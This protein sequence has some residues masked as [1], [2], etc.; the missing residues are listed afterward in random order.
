MNNAYMT[1]E[2]VLN[3]DVVKDISPELREKAQHLTDVVEALQHIGGSS[4]WLVLKQFVFDVDLSKARSS[5]EKEKDTTEMFRLQGEIRGRKEF[6]L[7]KLLLK[8][9]SDLEAIRQKL[10]A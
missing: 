5:L 9:R 8:K 1:S 4:H 6:N 3:E 10:N 7:E 2:N